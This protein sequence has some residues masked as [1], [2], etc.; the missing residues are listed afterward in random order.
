MNCCPSSS[1]VCRQWVWTWPG[2]SHNRYD[3]QSHLTCS[4]LST[5]TPAGTRPRRC[6]L[7]TRLHR[8]DLTTRLHRFDLTTRLHRFD[9]TTRLHRFDLTEVPMDENRLVTSLRVYQGYAADTLF[10][11][12]P[13]TLTVYQLV[14]GKW[15]ACRCYAVPLLSTL[16]PKGR[17]IVVSITFFLVAKSFEYFETSWKLLPFW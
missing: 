1:T 2:V 12:P 17:R 5:H 8:F 15:C 14:S 13:V 10:E 16:K 9:L 4:S 7:T 3:L 6:D 11:Y